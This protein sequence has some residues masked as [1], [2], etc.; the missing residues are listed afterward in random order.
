MMLT[1]EEIGA[2]MP[3]LDAGIKA[4]GVQIFQNNGGILIQSVL[5]KL[6]QMVDGAEKN[7]SPEG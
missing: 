1:K 2:L 4:A 5:A 7:E 6:Q 3:V